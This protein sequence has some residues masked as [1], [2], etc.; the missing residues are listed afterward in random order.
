M[1]VGM[2]LNRCH[3]VDFYSFYSLNIEIRIRQ[4]DVN[5]RLLT[6][7]YKIHNIR[8]YTVRVANTSLSLQYI[9][10]N[11]LLFYTLRVCVCVCIEIDWK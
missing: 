1:M 5:D 9:Y 8:V 10:N 3:R 4:E 6:I 11:I 7:I 2:C